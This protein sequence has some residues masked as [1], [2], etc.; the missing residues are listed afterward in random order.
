V[1]PQERWYRHNMDP[2]G[3]LVVD[4]GANVG[5]LSQF[6]WDQGDERTRVVSVEPLPQNLEAL[7]KRVK[8]ADSERWRVEACAVSAIDGTVWIEASRSDEHGW[9]A[10]VRDRTAEG[11]IEVPCRRLSTLVPDATLVK[12]DIEGH[13]YAVLDEALGAMTQVRA[14]AVE[15]HMVTGHPLQSTLTAFA[16]HGYTIV[17]AGQ[18]PGD[19]GTWRNIPVPTSLGWERIPVAQRR[20]DGS[21][22]KMLHIIAKRPT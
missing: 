4:V 8:A 9:N 14:W 16:D 19:P 20:P 5:R 22:F 7:A 13:E 11:F 12:L 17:A 2:R 15:L 6:F 21:I 18:H 1:D 10:A 3:Q